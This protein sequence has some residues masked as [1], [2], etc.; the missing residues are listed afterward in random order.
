MSPAVRHEESYDPGHVGIKLLVVMS[1]AWFAAWLFVRWAFI[2]WLTLVGAY[3]VTLAIASAAQAMGFR[4]APD[5]TSRFFRTAGWF[6]LS[7]FVSLVFLIVT[8]AGVYV[9]T[10]RFILRH[11]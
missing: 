10:G 9:W 6:V 4:I 11:W 5:W 2:V 1:F 8:V 3:A 7:G